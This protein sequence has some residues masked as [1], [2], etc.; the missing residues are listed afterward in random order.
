MTLDSF[1]AQLEHVTPR[2]NG[3]YAARC[4]AHIDRS[5]S[6]SI[7]E[8]DKG[9]LLR[10][11]AGCTVAEI[12]AALGL[13]VGDLFFDR[14]RLAPLGHRPAPTPPRVDRLARAFQF[15]LGAL[16]LRVRAEKIIEAGKTLDVARLSDDERDRAMN[17]V[18]KAYDDMARA[19]IF[20]SVADGLRMKE[21]IERDH[22]QLRR[23]A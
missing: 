14:G 19:E 17:T 11:F 8:G 9:L 12:S 20:E 3:R 6:L 1:L 13:T 10:C 23:T 18:A 5:P 15:E 16:D 4:P 2:G 21:F 22:E 7:S